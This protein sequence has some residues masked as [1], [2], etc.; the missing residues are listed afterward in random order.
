[1]RQL[2]H[3]P[4][5]GSHATAVPSPAGSTRLARPG[6]ALLW[7]LLAL[8]GGC[9][10]AI[11]GGAPTTLNEPSSPTAG[12]PNPLPVAAQEL[13]DATSVAQR[14]QLLQRRLIMID[15]AYVDFISTLRRQKTM[16]DL[17]T[18]LAGLAIGVAGTLTDGVTAKTNYAA[19]G[20]LL[21][22][23]T[24]VVDQTLYYEQT[25]LA[26][27]AA[28][29]ANRAAI[30]VNLLKGMNQDLATYSAG[31][32][33]AD[34]Q[35][36]ERAGTLLSAIGYIQAQAKQAKDQSDDT[37]RNIVAL[38]P[39]QYDA[40]TCNTRSLYKNNPK[41]TAANLMNAANTLGISVAPADQTD[42]NAIAEQIKQL[43]I[44]ANPDDIGHIAAALS[45]AGVLI[46]C[47]QQ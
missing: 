46:D 20:T 32:A 37:I 38:T 30:R 42:A 25:V 14:N 44:D 29:D 47:T 31:D 43:N 23:G 10:H 6:L 13:V 8:L 45:N 1:M 16:T 12:S 35:S 18:S 5:G 26:L 4:I 21:A 39:V 2:Q 24:A 9:S 15:A 33:Y 41:R 17:A 3:R 28:M 19:A 7:M 34:L 11:R 40:K 27:V 22:G 36:Y